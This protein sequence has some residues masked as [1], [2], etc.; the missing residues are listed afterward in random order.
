MS[1]IPTKSAE[2]ALGLIREGMVVG[3]GSGRAA[4]AFV[5]ALGEKVRAGLHVRCIPTSSETAQLA[6]K[7]Q[8]PLTNFEETDAIDVTVD[9][10]DEV[11]P[12]LNLIKGLGGAL[13]REKIVAS[14]SRML[15]ICVGAEKEVPILGQHGVLPVEIVPFALG[16]CR[17][18]I[19]A[20]GCP[21]ALRM[22]DDKPFITDNK[23]HI[24]DCRVGPITDPD[25]LNQALLAIPGVVDTG[26]FLG[27]AHTV[28]IQEGNEVRVRYR[29]ESKS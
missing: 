26:L 21:P 8:I 10:A 2:H 1:D 6:E 19:A 4:T 14:S 13:V 29:G 5:H 23:N 12:Q 28:L 22:H 24:F 27:M 7:L 20:L 17:R 18:R 11:D 15:V 25:A 16:F 9:G 3:L